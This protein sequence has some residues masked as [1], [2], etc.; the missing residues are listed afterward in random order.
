[1]DSRVCVG[2]P[3]SSS[4]RRNNPFFFE[5]IYFPRARQALQAPAARSHEAEAAAANDDEHLVG[6]ELLDEALDLLDGITPNFIISAVSSA[7]S[8]SASAANFWSVVSPSAMTANCLR[9]VLPRMIFT[10]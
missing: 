5:I 8:P 3:T 1:M 9:V 4:G 2:P 10:V 7:C 6:G